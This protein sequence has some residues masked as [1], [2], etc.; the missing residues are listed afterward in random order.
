MFVFQTGMKHTFGNNAVLTY[1]YA[2]QTYVYGFYKNDSCF[3]S[4][5][6]DQNKNRSYDE[7]NST[8]NDG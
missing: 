1:A 2:L 3:A 6:T 4:Q 7:Q 8:E 5:Y